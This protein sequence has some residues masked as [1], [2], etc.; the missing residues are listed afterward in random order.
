MRGRF[1]QDLTGM[2]FG[3]LVV[4]GRAPNYHRPSN[5]K[6]CSAVWYCQCDCGSP[7]KAVRATHLKSGAVVSCG[8]VG[9]T[10]LKESK[11]RHGQA[12]TRLYGVWLNMRN[13]CY[14]KNVRS[15]SNY[16][17][18]GITI[19]D[20]WRNDF[21]AFSKWAFANGYDPNAPF[22]KCTIDRID[23]DGPYSPE[24]CRFV[25]AKVQANN[26]RGSKHEERVRD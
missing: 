15:Y 26:R 11:I 16:G 21:S 1:A 20:E 10:H 23:V 24:N 19:C 17:S 12:K 9:K 18:R 6:Q 5:S 25:D 8:C 4:T 13:R 22:M 7:A 2:R 3:N 14:N